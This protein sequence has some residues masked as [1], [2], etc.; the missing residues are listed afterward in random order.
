MQNQRGSSTLELTITVVFFL[1]VLLSIPIL[2]RTFEDFIAVQKVKNGLAEVKRGSNLWLGTELMRTRCL[3]LQ[4]PLNITTLINENLL[5]D[6]LQTLEWTFA[7]TLVST[8]TNPIWQRPTTI[9]TT[10]TIADSRL[11]AAVQAALK[12]MRMNGNNLIFHSP[13]SADIANT[14]ALINRNT[15]CLQ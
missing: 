14:L 4:R 7:V 12:P 1:L 5:D 8:T 10:V 6:Q 15:G 11:R 9:L 13:I 2:S 3:T